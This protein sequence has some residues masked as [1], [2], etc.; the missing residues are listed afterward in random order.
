MKKLITL[1]LGITLVYSCSTSSDGNG[2]NTTTVVPV[3]PSNLTG[4]VASTTQ[5]NLSWTDNSTNETGFKIERKTG[6]GT[7]AIVGTIG[8]DVRTFNDNGLTSST[9]Y[10]Y[11]VYSYNSG[12]NSPTYSNELTIT[13]TSNTSILDFDG[14][15]YPLVTI[16]NQVWT[17][18]NLN[19]SRYR[20][21]DIIPQVTDSNQW[22]TL[23]T[24]AWCYYQN[25]TSIGITYGKLYNWYAVTDP[26]GL[27]PVGYHIPNTTEWSTMINFLDPNANGGL[28][29]PNVSGG[30][31]KEA[32][33][34]NWL[35]PNTSALNSSEFT[36]LPGGLCANTVGS[37]F[38]RLFYDGYWWSKTETSSSDA[39]C[40]M[41]FY[42][43]GSAYYLS[44]KKI[45]GLSVRCVK[46]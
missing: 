34:I 2:N 12:G 5:I 32:G 7:F 26:R 20:N 18:T 15:S 38:Q 9:T 14:N 37:F 22:L 17:K 40:Y 4:T 36:G 41:L 29:T 46:D 39:T 42:S 19:V 25:A 8:T 31:M 30:A 33:T 21:G 27:A 35:A 1:I 13:T 24:G 6:T 43:N 28:T 45:S 23:T 16:G 3:A 44:K 11:R 10:S